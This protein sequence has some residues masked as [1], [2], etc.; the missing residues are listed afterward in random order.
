LE[1]WLS[2]DRRLCRPSL[3]GERGYRTVDVREPPR[4]QA[5]A[6]R[7]DGS[8]SGGVIAR[9]TPALALGPEQL[10]RWQQLRQGVT[11]LS[12]PFF[13]PAFTS[14]VAQ[15]RP[16]VYVAELETDEQA[17][18]FFPFERGRLGRGLPV[19]SIL[20]DFHGAIV[21]LEASFDARQL[22][23]ACGLKTWE[24]HNL[25]CDQPAFVPFHHN[26]DDSWLVDLSHGGE[27]YMREL[28]EGHRATLARVRR[29]A[30]A[31]ERS[32]GAI[33]LVVHSGDP[34][35]LE[36]LFRWKSDQYA[37]TGAVEILKLDWVRQ[38]L[39]ATQQA[40]APDY[41]GVLTLLYAGERPVAAHL[42]MRSGPVLHSWF[43]AYDPEL[44]SA[45]PGLIL[46]LELLG[47]AEAE[48]ITR[49]DLGV[50]DYPFKKLFANGSTA[51]AVGSVERV[52][53]A[54]G[55]ARARRTTRSVV[56]R[57]RIAPKLR[58]AARRL[59]EG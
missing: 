58:N 27:S 38:V 3:P 51:V 10:A 11:A 31:L 8:R 7:R 22:I 29:K 23:R 24:F 16:E 20:S 33:R 37:R 48:G 35:D 17:L 57:T 56:R 43:Q 59:R 52:S 54:A 39:H 53:I 49:V 19:G 45:S 2:W 41:A 42:G 12:S 34:A 6:Y 55:A 50:G 14:I 18:G 28:E 32:H 15:A 13:S 30:R 1:I 25:I 4:L 46:L 47:C 26:R 40:Q 9:V 36:T 44:G 21:P 5:S